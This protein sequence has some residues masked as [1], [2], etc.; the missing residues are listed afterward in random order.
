MLDRVMEIG[1][2]SESKLVRAEESSPRREPWESGEIREAPARGESRIPT[3]Y[4][5]GYFLAP[6]GLPF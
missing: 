3:A 4:A 1:G 5:M 6:Y 2:C